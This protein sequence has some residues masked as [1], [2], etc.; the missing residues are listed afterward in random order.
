MKLL[1]SLI[2]LGSIAFAACSSDATSQQ[3]TAIV[4]T[5]TSPTTQLEPKK[6]QQLLATNAVLIDVRNPDEV[7]EEAYNVP[8]KL[9][10]P[11]SELEARL[12]EVPKDKQVVVACQRGGRSQKAF[13]LLAKLGYH[14]VANLEGG[15]EAWKGQGLPTVRP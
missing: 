3:S 10:I 14:N 11:L 1:N 15:M 4:S 13:D 8:N 5:Y 6:A 7:A 9:N 12:A 2:F